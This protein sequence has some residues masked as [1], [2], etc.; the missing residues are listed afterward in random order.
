MEMVFDLKECEITS[1][2][3]DETSTFL[4]RMSELWRQGE[5]YEVVAAL[6]IAIQVLGADEPADDETAKRIID[7]MAIIADCMLMSA[8]VTNATRPRLEQ[9]RNASR[10]FDGPE[11]TASDAEASLA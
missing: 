2:T 11:A 7:E 10:M 4:E 3:D 6:E 9:I 8:R 1:L 5:N